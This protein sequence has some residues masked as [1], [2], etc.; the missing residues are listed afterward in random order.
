MNILEKDLLIFDYD[1]TLADTSPLHHQAFSEALDKF[2][3]EINYDDIAG[4]KTFD[5]IKYILYKNDIN[6]SNEHLIKLSYY[7]QDIVKKL[8]INNL[9]PIYGVNQFLNWAKNK[10]KLCIASSGSRANVLLGLEKLAYLDL[11]EHIICSEDV[12]LAKPDPEIFFKVLNLSGCEAINSLIFEDSNSGIEAAK[13]SKID[14]IDVR[15]ISFLQLL[16]K[17]NINE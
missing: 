7:K 16:N 5:A 6:L 9:K 14:F 11:F 1:G 8:I 12:T 3:L 4:M 13:L 10:F 15:T 17:Y 2:D